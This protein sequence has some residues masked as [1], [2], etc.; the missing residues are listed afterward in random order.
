[1]NQRKKALILFAVIVLFLTLAALSDLFC[2]DAARLTDF[3]RKNLAPGL[4]FPFGTDWMGRDMMM[5]TLSGLSMSIRIGLCTACISAFLAL[6]LGSIA[7]LLGDRA[8]AAVSFVID[9]ILGIPH[10][11]LLILISYAFGKGFKGVVIGAALTH[12]P[13]LARV[14]RAEILQL[15]NSEYILIAGKLGQSRIQIA[16]VHMLPHLLPQFITGL[17]LM[18]PHAILHE[19]SI[20]FL[21]FGL[22]P[23][24]PALG[25]ILSESMRYLITGN[26]WLAVFPGA[27]LVLTVLLF[28]AAGNLLRKIWDPVSAQE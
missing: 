5:R 14:I 15:K 22:S 18:F 19:S 28:E 23:E 10:I 6:I 7:A 2:C 24:Q 17:V 20:T 27:L 21:G 3:S 1:M 13:S 8:D 9:A 4:E 25:I 11:L 12:W 16:V 26:W